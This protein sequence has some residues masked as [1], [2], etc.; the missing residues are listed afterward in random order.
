MTLARKTAPETQS[1]P[2]GNWFIDFGSPADLVAYLKE[3]VL[4]SGKTRFQE[5]EIFEN[6][7]WGRVLVLDGRMQSA[8]RDEFIYH[9]ALVHPA[10]LAHPEPRRVLVMGGGEGATL[11]EVLR[12]SGVKRAVMVDIDEELVDLCQEWLPSF[13]AGAFRDP[14][15]EMVFADG[16]GWLAAQADGSFEVIILDLTEPL[17]QG[18]ALRLFT[19]EMYETVQ[20]KLAPGGLTAVQSGSAGPLGRLMPDLNCTLRAVFPRVTA[21]ATFVPSFMELYGFHLAG[22]EDFVWPSATEMASRLK[23]QGVSSWRWLDPGLGAA[24]PH[25]PVY[26]QERLNQ[27]GRVLTDASPFG[28]RPG[29]RTFF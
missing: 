3:K 17:E 1:W 21:Y 9:E 16:R 2:P 6:R 27:E 20:R 13:H 28:P 8:E 18:P 15:T 29:E 26:L 12:Y 19:R 5:Y 25:L 22:G 7:L 24:L 14:R 11:R 10:L 23:A 4:V